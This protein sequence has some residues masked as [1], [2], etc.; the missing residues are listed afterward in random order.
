MDGS[1]ARVLDRSELFGVRKA[2]PA[3]V[4]LRT[5]VRRSLIRSHRGLNALART[6]PEG[7]LLIEAYIAD[8]GGTPTPP[9]TRTPI[10][11]PTAHVVDLTARMG[12]SRRH[13][14]LVISAGRRHIADGHRLAVEGHQRAVASRERLAAQR[15][16]AEQG[17]VPA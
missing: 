10:A 1:P 5:D 9:E 14:R 4:A 12:S 8:W 2:R 15:L 13:A 3:K 6:N 16:A 17:R 11:Q 7:A